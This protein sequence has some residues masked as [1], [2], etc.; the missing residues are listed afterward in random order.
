MNITEHAAL[1]AFT[2]GYIQ[3]ALWSTCDDDGEPL[4]KDLDFRDLSLNCGN[5]MIADC[6]SFQESFGHLWE[7]AT[8]S[9]IDEY[10]GHDFWLTRNGHGSGFWGRPE[11]YGEENAER[12]TDVSIESGEVNLYVG[13]DMFI[14]SN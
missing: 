14:H 7:N 9:E 5:Q 10:A 4:D 3:A 8:H 13:D 2:K 12:L 1:D 6:R 11:I